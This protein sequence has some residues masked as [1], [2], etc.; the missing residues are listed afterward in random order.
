MFSFVFCLPEDGNR[1]NFRNEMVSTN[2]DDGHG[3]KIIVLKIT[4]DFI[5]PV[6]VFMPI[7]RCSQ[8]NRSSLQVAFHMPTLPENFIFVES[9]VFPSASCHKMGKS[10]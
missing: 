3:K 1:T 5:R 2:L 4:Y 9:T 8:D 10:M 7:V 6:G